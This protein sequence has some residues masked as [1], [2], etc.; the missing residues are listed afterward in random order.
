MYFHASVVW[1]QEKN[2]RSLISPLD[3]TKS[4]SGGSGEEK[5]PVSGGNQ[6]RSPS[7]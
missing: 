4:Q 5:N 6:T 1:P 2:I 3:G 7:P